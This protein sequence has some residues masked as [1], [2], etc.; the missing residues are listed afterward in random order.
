MNKQPSVDILMATYNGELFVE[1]QID[2]ILH[3]THQNFHLII[4][5]DGST[6]RTRLL[7]KQKAQQFPEKIRFIDSQER[8]GVVGNF[9]ALMEH[10]KADYIL[11]S[12]Q[13]DVW[14]PEK[15]SKTLQRM[16]ELETK[17][18]PETALLV[19]TDLQVVD[20]NLQQIAPS[21]W[22]YS[23]LSP[24]KSGELPRMLMQNVVTGCTIMINKPLLLLATPVPSGVI[25]HDWWIGLVA[26]AL[27]KMDCIDEPTILY[28]Q[29][30][31]NQVGAK[32]KSILSLIVRVLRLPNE[33]AERAKAIL[34]GLHKQGSIFLEV[35]EKRLGLSEQ[36]VVKEFLKLEPEK[37]FHNAMLIHKNGFYKNGL[38]KNLLLILLPIFLKAKGKKA[39]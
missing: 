10:A 37:F 30:A 36:Y 33:E 12:D 28:R 35:F 32:N 31:K 18:G 14:L 17:Y 27:G 19:H 2:S 16:Q 7:I 23:R 13:D 8:F 1:E 25:M 4:R 34:L 3:Q 15:V 26:S 11:F 5:D 6:D 22:S 38:S 29:H 39:R 9:S 24:K 21:F 20:Q